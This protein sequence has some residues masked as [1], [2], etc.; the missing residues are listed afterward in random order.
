[1]KKLTD[2]TGLGKVILLCNV[3]V[4]VLFII[5]ML[6]LMKFDKTNTAVIQERNHYNKLYEG[7]VTAQH[8]FSAF[9]NPEKPLA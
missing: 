6:F 4:L 2:N 7:Y 1:M 9:S 3:V 8:P 5:S